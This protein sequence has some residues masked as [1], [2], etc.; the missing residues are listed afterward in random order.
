MLSTDCWSQQTDVSSHIRFSL[1][2]SCAKDMAGGFGISASM[3]VSTVPLPSRRVRICVCCVE[4]QLSDDSAEGSVVIHDRGEPS[5]NGGNDET[6]E[7]AAV[8]AGSDASAPPVSC[9]GLFKPA[10]L[11]VTSSRSCCRLLF[12]VSIPSLI[13]WFVQG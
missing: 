7:L 10:A 8:P 12:A 2:K 5:L 9:S 6:V 3:R 11:V 4:G 1:G 13:V